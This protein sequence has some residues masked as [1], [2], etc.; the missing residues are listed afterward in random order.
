MYRSGK[1]LKVSFTLLLLAW[2]LG[3]ATPARANLR[4]YTIVQQN[5]MAYRVATDASQMDLEEESDGSLTFSLQL[6]SRRNNYEE[7]MM[8]GY[9]AVGQAVE[10]TDLNVQTIHIIV[11]T[12]NSIIHTTADISLVEQLLREEINSFDFIRQLQWSSN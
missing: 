4:F 1:H 9:I 10:R 8:I 6:E 2:C 7:V 3:L 12:P 5:C 11:T